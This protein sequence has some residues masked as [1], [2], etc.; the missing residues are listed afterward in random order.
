MDYGKTIPF[1]GSS[2]AIGPLGLTGQWLLV[3][4]VVAVAVVAFAIRLTFRRD[5]TAFER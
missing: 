2:L 3:L 1:A 4:A 5:R